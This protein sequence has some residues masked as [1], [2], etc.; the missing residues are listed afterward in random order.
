MDYPKVMVTGHRPQHLT[1]PQDDFARA[2][3]DRIAQKLVAENGMTVGISGMAIGADTYW[4]YSVL[5]AGAELWGF[6]PFPQQAAKWSLYQRQE[7]DYLRGRCART[8]VGADRFSVGAL[9]ARNDA[10]LAEADLVVAVWDVRKMQ[11]G[12]AS[13]VQK[14]MRLGKP[15]IHI[16]VATFETTARGMA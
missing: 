9:H 1:I 7:W 8:W 4:C 12:T 6:I 10:M 11:G 3:L 14:A 15:I 5:A 13:C 2:E 16:N